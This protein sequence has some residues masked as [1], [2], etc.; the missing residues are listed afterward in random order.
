MKNRKATVLSRLFS[1]LA[2]LAG[3][4]GVISF[5]FYWDPSRKVIK[6]IQASS[7]YKFE[8]I[9]PKYLE[10]DPASFIHIGSGKTVP[11]VRAELENVVWGEEGFPAEQLPVQVEADIRKL[12]PDQQCPN[13][14]REDY[15]TRTVGCSL[16][17]YE[18]TKNLAALERLTIDVSP[19]YHP[20]VSHFRPAEGNGVL[21]LYHH[22]YA[23]THQDQWRHISRWVELGYGVMAFDYTGYGNAA[24]G[25]DYEKGGYFRSIAKPIAVALNYALGEGGYKKAHMVGL[26]AGGWAT[27]LYAVLDLRISKSYPVSGVY[28]FFLRSERETAA[29]Q[30][31]EALLN[32]ASYLDMFILASSGEGRG[33]MQVFNRFDRCCFNGLRSSIYEGAVANSVQAIGRGT[34]KVL[35]DETHARHKISR[36]A[37]EEILKDMERP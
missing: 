15:T 4:L 2:L 26:S 1:S 25:V 18:G 19:S 33:Q 13:R 6:R 24:P 12:S 30:L 22:G 37:F 16:A 20:K 21:V 7:P 36:W 29:P 27:A 31:D 10:V 17:L 32:A 35:L 8:K 14:T 5:L 11:Q 9:D 28:P 3:L 34:F 23:G